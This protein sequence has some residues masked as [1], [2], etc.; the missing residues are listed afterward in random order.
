MSSDSP[1]KCSSRLS[2][3]RWLVIYDPDHTDGLPAREQSPIQ[4]QGLTGPVS[5]NY[6]D[7]GNALSTTLFI[8]RRHRKGSRC[9]LIGLCPS[10]R[11]HIVTFTRWQH[12]KLRRFSPTIIAALGFGL[13]ISL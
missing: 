7:R 4:L 6:V 1:V 5:I 13:P 9:M 2:R 3:P 10:D 8:V 11:T 12:T